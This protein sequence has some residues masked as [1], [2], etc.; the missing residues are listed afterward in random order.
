MLNQN[1]LNEG[2]EYH[3]LKVKLGGGKIII[4]ATQEYVSK[5]DRGHYTIVFENNKGD[6]LGSVCST[7]GQPEG[8]LTEKDLMDEWKSFKRW[9]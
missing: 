9:H 7:C 5:Y 4:K 2:Y 1:Q 3:T 6:I 8:K